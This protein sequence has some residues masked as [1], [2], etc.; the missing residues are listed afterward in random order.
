MI[1]QNGQKAVLPGGQKCHCGTFAWACNSLKQCQIGTATC[2]PL[3]R[4]GSRLEL[5]RTRNPAN[6]AG[7]H[8]SH[9]ETNQP[10]QTTHLG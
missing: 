7:L 8:S 3:P 1:A 10:D 4:K 5:L 9:F 6:L 2:A